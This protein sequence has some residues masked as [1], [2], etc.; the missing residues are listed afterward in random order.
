M[1]PAFA[2]RE[3]A[4]HTRTPMMD[5]ALRAMTRGELRWTVTGWVSDVADGI[6]NT[7]TINWLAG[8]GLCSKSANRARLTARGREE[9]AMGVWA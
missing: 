1:R 6:W 7:H 3:E 4:R 8:K 2:R 9:L 5:T